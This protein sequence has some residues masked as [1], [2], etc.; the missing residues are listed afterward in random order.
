MEYTILEAIELAGLAEH[1][2]LLLAEGW[3]PLGGV[4]S[5]VIGPNQHFAQAMLREDNA[6]EEEAEIAEVESEQPG[7]RL[8]MPGGNDEPV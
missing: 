1:V 7:P 2:N 6:A 3:H 8:M 5:L 4:A